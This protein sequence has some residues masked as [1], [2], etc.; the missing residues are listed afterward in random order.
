MRLFLSDSKKNLLFLKKFHLPRYII[1]IKSKLIILCLV[2]GLVPLIILGNLVY[3]D[4]QSELRTNTYERMDEIAHLQTQAI[5]QWLTERQVEMEVLASLTGLQSMDA[6]RIAPVIQTYFNRWKIY[7]NITVIGLD[8]QTIYRTDNKN[9]NLA[10]R[11]Y[12][13]RAI[14]GEAVVSDPVISKASGDAVIVVAVPIY[15]N[16]NIVGVVTGAISTNRFSSLLK[17]ANNGQTGEAYLINSKGY[18]VTAPRSADELK[19]VGLIKDRAE[20][21]M[22]VHSLGAFRALGGT[23]GV[24]EYANYYQKQVVGAYRM[25]NSTGWGLLVEQETSE[26]FASID[27]LRLIVVGSTLCTA[28]VI[29]LSAFYFANQ[30]ATPIQRIAKTAGQ[31]ADVDLNN[32]AKHTNVLATGDL[33]GEMAFQ[34]QSIHYHS[35]DEVD[36]LANSFNEIISHLHQVGNAYSIMK[37]NLAKL[38]G[39]ILDCASNLREASEQL[40]ISSAQAEVSSGE[41]NNNLQQVTGGISDQTVSS[42]SSATSMEQL[43]SVI[44]VVALGAQEQATA[45]SQ[46]STDLTKVDQYIA[47]VFEKSQIAVKAASDSAQMVQKG[48]RSIDEITSRMGAIKE[49]AQYAGNTVG[50]MGRTSNQIGII[51]ETIDEIASQ[52]NLLALNATIEAARAGDY[53]R[54]FAVV[55]DEV[56]K[57]AEKSASAAKEITRLIRNVQ[58]SAKDAGRAVDESLDEVGI[59]VD[60]AQQSGQTLKEIFHLVEIVNQKTEETDQAMISMHQVYQKLARAIT[61]VSGVIEENTASAEEMAASSGEVSLLIASI[62][63]VSQKNKEAVIEVTNS[64]AEMKLHVNRFNEA[65]YR[66][67]QMETDLNV[68]VAKF[69][70]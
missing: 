64:M 47:T 52:T 42:E 66:L 9:L 24:D 68:A 41:I 51:V 43:S 14:Q 11:D 61:E 16:A 21:E 4:S 6:A 13:K 45:V 19:K 25:I 12:F 17:I 50:E 33:T 7:D 23:P 44:Q 18:F 1:N 55:A 22:Q 20:M 26:A 28:L 5:D 40:V 60:Q 30:I 36:D 46:A 34:T 56:R 59:G 58:K 38:I 62:S 70:I 8:G 31:I 63:T 54:G 49:K 39:D 37:M 67:A 65:A 69:K 32:L 57:L 27:R 35:N 2:L 15:D 10:D 53:G 48:A 29:I 3:L